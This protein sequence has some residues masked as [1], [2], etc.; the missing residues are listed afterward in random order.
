M[1]EHAQIDAANAAIGPE[2]AGFMA[3]ADLALDSGWAALESTGMRH[4]DI[5]RFR[6]LVHENSSKDRG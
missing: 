6:F 5:A 2:K 4:C 3:V 1:Q